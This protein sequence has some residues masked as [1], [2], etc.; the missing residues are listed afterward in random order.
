MRDFVRSQGLTYLAHVMRRVSDE[1]VKSFDQWY[2]DVGMKAP[3]RTRSTLL[4]LRQHGS[5]GVVELSDL[6]SQSHPLVITWL[7]QLTA[8]GMIRMQTDPSDRRRTV[9][10]LTPRGEAE[11]KKG[12]YSAKVAEVA[13]KRLLQETD[14][15]MVFE[16]I[17]RMEE[18]CRRKPFIERL[19]EASEELG[20]PAWQAGE[21]TRRTKRVA[22]H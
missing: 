19:R 9:V 15:E 17:W 16:A 11:A 22:N 13:Y 6:L 18:A 2:P 7:R 3:A 12:S 5:L 20:G 4:A 10:T 8:L 21:R 1:F 14:A